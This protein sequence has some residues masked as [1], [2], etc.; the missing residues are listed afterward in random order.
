MENEALELIDMLY[1]MISDAWGIPLGNEK[2]IIERDKALNLLEELKA[3]LPT[4]L[5]AAKRLMASRDAFVDNA[6]KEAE[7]IRRSAEEEARR[8]VDEQEIVLQAR[9][10]GSEI[11]STAEGRSRN[12]MRAAN[13][14]VDD[15]M[16]RTEEA[17]SAA[18]EEVRQSHL[19]F[20]NVA[21]TSLGGA[22]P[23]PEG[24]EPVIIPDY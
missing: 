16:R 22:A 13:E 11:V 10:L 17:I 8:L 7:D 4:E 18:L 15:T 19:R 5:A 3:Q 12:L 23:M 21:S 24:E 20:K 6:K 14:Y 9:S 1:T 2:C